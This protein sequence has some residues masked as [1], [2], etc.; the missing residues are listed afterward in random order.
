M[1]LNYSD[2]ESLRPK[3]VPRCEQGARQFLM[4]TQG[5][6]AASQP[7]KDWCTA[8]MPNLASLAEQLSHYCLSEPTFIDGGTSITD[9]ALQ[10]RIEFVL[11]T[12][13]MPA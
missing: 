9:A 8:N 6:G 7:R 4:Y 1:A 11:Q 3:L 5:N 12:Y 13:F 10:S 2:M